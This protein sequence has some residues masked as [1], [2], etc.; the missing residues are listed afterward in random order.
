MDIERD[1]EL[2]ELVDE[3][4]QKYYREEILTVANDRAGGLHIDWM[5]MFKFNPDFA[6]WFIEEPETVLWHLEDG[7]ANFNIPVEI[8]L[9][10]VEVR[11][12]NLESERVYNPSELRHE[13]GNTYVGIKGE[14]ARI[15]SPADRPDLLAYT[16]LRCGSVTKVPQA[17]SDLQEPYQCEDCEREGPFEINDQQSEWTD[18]SKIRVKTPPDESGELGQSHIDGYVTGEMVD[19]GHD[20]YGLLARAGENCTVYGIVER[21]QKDGRGENNSLFDRI[22]HIKAIEFED[23]GKK[24]NIE[25]HK[26]E[27]TE[28]SERG[29]AV[30]IF[31]QSLAPELYATP[32]WEWALELLVAYLFSAPRIDINDG[33][34]YRGD[35]HVLIV[36]DYGLGKSTVNR[37]VARYSPKSIKE[38]VTGMSSEVGLLAASVK[39]DFGEGQW[40]LKPGV[41]VRGNGGHVILDEIDKTDADLER[42]NDALEGEQKVDI[43][44]AGQSVTYKSRV[45]LLGTGNPKDSRFNGYDSVA[46]QL[47]IGD[48]LLSRFDGIVTM[49]DTP[50]SDVDAEVAQRVGQA[51]KEAQEY[52]YGDRDDFEV[53]DRVVDVDVGRSWIAY[54]RENIYPTI[55][56]K[57]IEDIRDW[58]A[59]EVRPL[60]NEFGSEDSEE[61]LP[62]PVTP[63]AIEDTIRLSVAFA[64]VHLRDTVHRED[65]ERAKKLKKTLVGQ[66]FRDG[67]AVPAEYQRSMSQHERKEAILDVLEEHGDMGQ[68]ELIS[69]CNDRGMD[70]GKVKHMLENWKDSAKS[71]IYEPEPGTIALV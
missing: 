5:D 14:L 16:C 42:M 67:K 37:A 34:T 52:D 8:S 68:N 10:D 55:T 57:Q 15:T 48:S 19:F 53:L 64:R 70:G 26:G 11:V 41:L 62:V 58:Y 22:L 50:D 60:N 46:E 56:E 30:K 66:T 39:D 25:K 35:I 18:Y 43:D 65:L 38:S 36:S 44:K 7:L 31:A 29:D 12:Y 49:R 45:G 4:L 21:V 63:R 32:E 3:F 1:H 54:A 17:G 24:V 6:D 47:D 71:P 28:L 2:T 40:T 13:H 20:E 33:P 59:N 61:D 69:E 9:D 51:Y 27:F 23:D